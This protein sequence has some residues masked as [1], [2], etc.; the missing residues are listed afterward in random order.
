[1]VG[2]SHLTGVLLMT[3][4]VQ[5]LNRTHSVVRSPKCKILPGESAELREMAEKMVSMNST[6]EPWTL[7]SVN[8]CGHKES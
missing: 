5:M 7:V 6:E 4:H 8:W 3:C 2:L 1:M